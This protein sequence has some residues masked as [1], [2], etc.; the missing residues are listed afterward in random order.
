MNE[1]ISCCYKI[2]LVLE[3]R[4][5]IKYQTFSLLHLTMPRIVIRKDGRKEEF[6]TEKIV[7]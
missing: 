6:I 7:V 5:F 3:I 1:Y 2:F 4:N